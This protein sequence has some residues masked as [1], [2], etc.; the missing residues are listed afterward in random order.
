MQDIESL[1]KAFLPESELR[2]LT[3][4]AR[5]AEA[6]GCALYIV[7]GF[8]RDF[9]LRRVPADYDL[10]VEGDAIQLAQRLRN[11]YG[12]R[13]ITHTRFRT[14]KWQVSD[15]EMPSA[16]GRQDAVRGHGL[17][18]ISARSEWY[19]GPARLPRVRLATIEDDLRRRDFTI[20][21]LAVRLD[22]PGSAVC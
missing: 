20:N 14:A 9:V 7:G 6:M 11:L 18:L 12:G 3:L 16:S 19:D 21:A 15:P 22:G 17:D 1:F 8:P 5:E 2:R 10:V 13:I 4:V